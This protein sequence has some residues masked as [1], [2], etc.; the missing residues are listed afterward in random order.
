ML[1]K[2]CGMRLDEQVKELDRITDFIGFIFFKN[3]KRYVNSTPKVDHAKKV[4]VF[5][6]AST[7]KVLQQIQEHALDVVQLHGNESPEECQ[8]LKKESTIIKAFGVNEDFDFAQTDAYSDHVDYFLF[9]TKTKLHG[10]SGKQF[11][12][13]LL[14]KYTGETPFILSGGITPQSLHAIRRIWHSK[15]AGVDLNSGFENA[16]SDK[17][18]N[19]L[20]QF[21]NQLQQ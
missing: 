8:V 3:S 20:K 5:V 7:D 19:E 18:I 9:D 4:G 15:L 6:N 16:P 12:W 2:V 17:N 21:I 10:G 13:S 14:K 11:D 1:I